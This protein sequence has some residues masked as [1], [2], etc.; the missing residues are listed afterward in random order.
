MTSSKV[1]LITL[2]TF[3]T[4]SLILTGCDSDEDYD[5]WVIDPIIDFGRMPRWSPDGNYIL[6]GGDTPDKSGLWLWE[7]YKEPKL[8]ADSLPPHNWDYHWSPDD[9]KIAFTAPGEPGSEDAGIWVVHVT[10]GDKKRLLDRGR[11]LCW[12]YDGSSVLVRIDQPLEG[13]PG[14][15]RVD[16]VDGSMEFIT[17]G[18]NPVCS[19]DTCWIAYNESEISGRLY[20]DNG[21]DESVVVTELGAVQWVWSADG[22]TLC[23]VVNDYVSGVIHGSLLRIRYNGSEWVAK[24]ITSKSTGYP[25]PNRS[26]SQITFLK[27]SENADWDG[28]WLYSDDSNDDILVTNFGF[29]PEFHP[30]DNDLI[31]VDTPEDGIRLM[32]RK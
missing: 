7:R 13:N 29:N 28:L 25:A 31:A 30:S 20:V 26:G 22:R 8:L 1:Q 24:K 11:D 6:F 2:I 23:C 17:A 4:L 18:F 9:D 12:Y 21:I 14:I 10:S 19:P 27:I 32:M 16:V 3:I 15:Y 5:R